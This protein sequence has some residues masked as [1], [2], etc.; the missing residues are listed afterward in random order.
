MLKMTESMKEVEIKAVQAL[1]Q[2]LA[3]V[4]AIDVKRIE[5]EAP[6]DRYHVDI[7]ARLS[8]GGRSHDLVCEVKANGQPRHVRE[9]LLQLGAYIDQKDKDATPVLIA[10]F[11]SPEAQELCREHN[12]GYLDL[13]GNCRLVFDGVFIERLVPT[14]P[15]A[16]RREIKSIFKPKAAQV[17]RI[18]LRDPARHWRVAELAETAESA[19]AMS[20]TSG[21][22]CS[23]GNGRA[24]TPKASG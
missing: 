17:L 12:A 4:P 19:S 11:L 2:L 9:A 16:Q 8:V 24:W 3:Q 1:K 23:T 22:L 7:L 5:T 21:R 10:P 14:S 20:A 15:P 18:M 6:R 13:E